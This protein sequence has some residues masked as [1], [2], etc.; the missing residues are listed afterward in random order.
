MEE[1]QTISLTRAQRDL[2]LKYEPYFED[3]A[4]FRLIS[5]A[6]KKGSEYEIYLDPEQADDLLDQVSELSNHEEN[7]KAQRKLDD[8]CDY[9]FECCDK[10]EEEEEEDDYY[11]EE[12]N[13]D[14]EEIDAQDERILKI[15][16][17]PEEIEFDDSIDKFYNYLKTNLSLP[18]E[19]TGIE[20]FQ[21]EEYYLL[22]PGSKKEYQRLK[23]T[24]PSHQDRFELLGIIRNAES[25]WAMC[26]E[27]DI[28]AS[29][30]RISDKKEFILGLSEIKATDKKSKN[31]ELLDDYSVWFVNNR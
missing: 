8:L 31:Y 19:V 17:D 24:N 12:E 22:G 2:L 7:E 13:L 11:D 15:V 6:V 18:C 26:E 29:V 23:E 5:I 27:D 3:P 28:G 30:R 16:G 10:E 25:E 21:W 14:D 9:L 1:K 4:L 20:D